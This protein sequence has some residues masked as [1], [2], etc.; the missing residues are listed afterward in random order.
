MVVVIVRATAVM[1]S[2]VSEK[3]SVVLSELGSCD[4]DHGHRTCA[5]IEELNVAPKEP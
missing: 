2:R 4:V 3:A 1:P 5:Q